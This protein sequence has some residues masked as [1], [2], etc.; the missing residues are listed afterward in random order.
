MSLTDMVKTKEIPQTHQDLSFYLPILCLYT[1][2]K[3][4]I[5]LPEEFGL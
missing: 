5:R 1:K 3:K 2:V 4:D